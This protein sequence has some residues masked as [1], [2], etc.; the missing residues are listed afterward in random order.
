MPAD[1]RSVPASPPGMALPMAFAAAG[2]TAGV[3][4]GKAIAEWRH[5]RRVEAR[6]PPKGRFMTLDGVRVHYF[7]TGGNGSSVVLLHGNG[8]S[9]DDMEASGL[10]SRLSRNHR[11]VAFDRPGFGYSS[12]P[13]TRLWTP[14][15]QA[16]LLAAALRRLDV[17]QPVIVGHSWATLVAIALALENE[18]SIAGL[19]LLSGYYFPTS[20]S[21][22]VM[23]APAALPLLG[24]LM[25]YTIMPSLMR[26]SLRRMLKKQFRP[27]AVASAFMRRFP[28]EL[29]LRPWQIRAQAEES[30]MM[31]PAAAA[32]RRRYGTLRLPTI[33]IAGAG[34]R[35]VSAKHQSARLAGKLRNGDLHILPGLGHMLHYAAGEE[36]ERA[37]DTLSR[38]DGDQNG[39]ADGAMVSAP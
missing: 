4:A 12:R 16:R 8:T 32:L 38:T 29:I 3:L 23:N 6:Y 35:V 39:V 25:N 10:L 15:A 36:I 5:A 28:I 20:R 1:S 34:D 26:L 21:D 37:I 19:V 33:I 9:V 30:A 27:R 31:V 2:A 18:G 13:R 24:D 22:A 11:V 17:R 7:D 14:A